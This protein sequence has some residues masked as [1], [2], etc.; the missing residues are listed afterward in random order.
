[1]FADAVR[2]ICSPL[3]GVFR[4]TVR[5]GLL[6]FVVAAAAFLLPQEVPLNYY[7]PAEVDSDRL[8]LAI[9][10]ASEQSGS[11]RIFYDTGRGWNERELFTWPSAPGRQPYTYFFPLPDA[12]LLGLRLE[13]PA[14]P[15]SLSISKLIIVNRGGKIIREIGPANFRAFQAETAISEDAATKPWTVSST[16]AAAQLSA[17]LKPILPQGMNERNLRQILFSSAYLGLMLWIPLLALAI[18]YAPHPW[19][20]RALV[21][22][23]VFLALLALL[24]S[25][26][27]HRGLIRESWRIRQY[28]QVT[29]RTSALSQRLHDARVDHFDQSAPRHS[30]RPH[31]PV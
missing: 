18:L 11:L 29:F 26:V 1:M 30:A 17:P 9:T 4:P 23:V 7:T 10:C 22:S 14:S 3:A 15:F 5:R 13:L 12:P 2:E 6:A 19:S 21:Q 25:L 28:Q 27:A 31:A 20:T 16:G 24:F 8:Q